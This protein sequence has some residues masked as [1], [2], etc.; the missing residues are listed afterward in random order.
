LGKALHSV[1][2]NCSW[3][4]AQGQGH[5]ISAIITADTVLLFV[6]IS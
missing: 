3:F 5:I 6:S 4:T 1:E 2:L